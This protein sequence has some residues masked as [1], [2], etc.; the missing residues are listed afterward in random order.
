[1]VII[2]PSF[3][4]IKIAN[5]GI[6]KPI[7]RIK[8]LKVS[9]RGE[10]YHLTFEVLPMKRRIAKNGSYLL[11][12]GCRILCTNKGVADWGAKISTFT[13]GPPHNRTKID[14]HRARAA[15]MSS[16][17]SQKPMVEAMEMID[18][19]NQ[20]GHCNTIKCIGPG[21]CDFTNDG[22]LAQ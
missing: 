3:S 7:G 2:E 21:L 15:K 9:T 17:K 1:M 6:C 12:L 4:T 20:L 11:L 22:T 19:T 14:I 8:D 5:Q 18:P 10:D 16:K 13:Y